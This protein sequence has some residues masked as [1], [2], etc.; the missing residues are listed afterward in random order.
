MTDKLKIGDVYRVKTSNLRLQQ[1]SILV[2]KALPAVS[3]GKFAYVEFD[4]LFG[5]V[6]NQDIIPNVYVKDIDYFLENTEKLEN[7][8]E[9]KQPRSIHTHDSADAVQGE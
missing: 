3:A 2:I 8:N 4:L 1:G 5:A 9:D 6:E 7:P